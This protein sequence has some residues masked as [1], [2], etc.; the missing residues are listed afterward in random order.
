VNIIVIDSSYNKLLVETINIKD[1]VEIIINNLLESQFNSSKESIIDKMK[2]VLL[3]SLTNYT[4][5]INF[6]ELNI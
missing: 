1:G 3:N 5:N 6:D 4:D 2:Q